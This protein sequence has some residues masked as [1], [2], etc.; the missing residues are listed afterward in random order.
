[1]QE[2]ATEKTETKGLVYWGYLESKDVM[3]SNGKFVG[4]MRG[5]VIDNNWTIPKVVIEVKKNI[6]DELGIEKP[7]LSV[8]LVELP[9]EY[10]RNG[11]DM[12]QLTGDVNSLKWKAELSFV[13]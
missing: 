8:A 9:S 4:V 7:L 13:P 1:M 2:T 11:T 5:I 12:V 3:D 10:V 6:L